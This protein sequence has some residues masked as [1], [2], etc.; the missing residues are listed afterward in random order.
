MIV[1]FVFAVLL[2]ANNLFMYFFK[3]SKKRIIITN[4]VLLILISSLRSVN[5]GTDT[6]AYSGMFEYF[7]ELPLNAPIASHLEGFFGYRVICKIVY[8]ISGGNYQIMLFVC[9]VIIIYGLFKY[10]YY[11]SDNATASIFY[12]I[13]LFFFKSRNNETSPGL[14]I[15]VSSIY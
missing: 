9:S 6:V 11:Y 13:T 14:M 10:I 1:Y 12:Y 3:V 5:I 15:L 4:A 8:F 2:I 7:G